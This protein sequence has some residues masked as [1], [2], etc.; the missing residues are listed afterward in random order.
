MNWDEGTEGIIKRN[1]LIGN[2][3][4][5]AE[6]ALK[7]GRTAEALL[8]AEAGG[9][10]LLDRIKEEYFTQSKDSYVKHFLRS[11]VQEDFKEIVSSQALHA[12]GSNWKEMI[13]YLLSYVEGE[14]LNG[15]VHELAEDLLNRKKDIN[16]A[17]ACYMI[18]Q[19]TET[20]V[21]LWKKRAHFY[22]KKGED[23]NEALF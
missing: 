5:A 7:A 23:R 9:K 22:I 8:I 15:F 12:K 6:V 11:I 18:S 20:V 17:I 21:D 14:E 19:S 2:L 13:A 1:L 3:E 16:S 4:C 10:A